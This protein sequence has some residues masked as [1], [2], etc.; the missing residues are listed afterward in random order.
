MK[1]KPVPKRAKAK[2][3]R[4]RPGKPAG[5]ESG[6]AKDVAMTTGLATQQERL[7]DSMVELCAEV[8][9]LSVSVAEVSTKAGVSSKTFYELFADKE[10]CLLAAYRSS[11]S[12]LLANAEPVAE[13]GDWREAARTVLERLLLALQEHPS[14]GRLLLV[15]ALA[16]GARVRTERERVL[17]LFEQRAQEFL[18]SSPR[19]GKVL[20]LPATALIGAVRSL[21]SRHLRTYG[22]DR[23]TLLVEDLLAWLESYAVPVGQKR[24]S[25]GP[26]RLLPAAA[27]K[28]LSV[29]QAIPTPGRLPRGRHRLPAGVVA[30]S[31]RTRI[32][33]GTAEVMMEKGYAEATVSEIV[34]AAA[35]SREVFYAHFANKQDAFLAAQQYATQYILESCTAAYFRA[36]TWP[37]RVWSAL[38]ALIGMLVAN[39]AL[40]HL[41]LVECYAAGPAAI[42]QTEQLKRAATIFL[43]EGFNWVPRPKGVPPLA[44]H[45][46][47]GAVFEVFYAHISQGELKQLPRSLPQLTYIAI[48]PFVGPKHAIAA[49]ERI[50]DRVVAGESV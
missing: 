30:R 15:E 24:W 3:E 45:A 48:A 16:G 35:I 41:R 17:G 42:E 12:R 38:D 1:T 22:E 2:R 8:G 18:D 14:A 36:N 11:A 29:E 32:V 9:Y 26:H 37:E 39:P 44:T 47:S 23:L 10:D 7:I 21:V 31:Q 6:A 33:Q 49:V 19:D 5:A 25:T 40:A 27:T 4:E 28:H 13:D 50:R 20:D 46:I 34:T 43:Q